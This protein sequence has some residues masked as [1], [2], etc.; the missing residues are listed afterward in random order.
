M[1]DERKQRAA[2]LASKKKL[3]ADYKDLEQQL[4]M[5]NKVKEDAL[6]QL[7]KLQAQLK[8]SLRDADEARAARDELATVNKETERKLKNLE[9]ELLQTAEDLAA[10]ER[11]KR[12]AEGER[13]E[14]QEEIT[15]NVSK[16]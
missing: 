6:K 14:L 1:D 10:C 11:Q 8:D 13:D 3:E 7:K 2:A 16:G 9:A 5:H 12:A 4:E 15:N